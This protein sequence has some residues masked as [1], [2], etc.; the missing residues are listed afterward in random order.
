MA[1]PLDQDPSS[2]IAL[3]LQAHARLVAGVGPLIDADVRADSRLPGWSIGH[4]LT[5]L[6][7]NADGHTRRLEGALAGQDLARYAGGRAQRS[8]DIDAGAYRS[9]ADI[10]TDV[11]ASAARLEGVWRACEEAGWP[12]QD[13]MADDDWP[14]PAS[15]VRR[16][17]EVEMHHADLGRG[18]DA[19]RWSDEYVAWELDQLLATVP[20]RL[21]DGT[22][23]RQL[24]NWLAGRGPQPDHLDLGPW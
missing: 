16:L 13:L 20:G 24:V 7:R 14:T 22:Q 21:P 9:A 11:M 18:Y 17:R 12:N 19:S 8:A 10:V 4:V 23:R 6:A 5:H 3:C 2:A 1:G 15:P